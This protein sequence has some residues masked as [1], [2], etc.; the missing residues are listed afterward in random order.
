MRDAMAEREAAP[1]AAVSSPAADDPSATLLSRGFLVLLAIAAIVGVAV[2]LAAWCF[3][4]LIYQMQQE[5]YHH[6][7]SALGYSSGPPIWWSLPILAVAGVI[8]AL[9]IT[10]LP[11]GGGHIPAEGLKVGGAPTRP[12][13]LP[14]VILAGLASIGLGLVIGP[15]A[16]LIALGAGLAVA[17]VRLARRQAPSQ[18]LLVVGAAGSFAALS[19]VFSSPIIAAVILIEATGLGKSR[20]PIV[21]IPGLVG[22]GIGSLV[23]I[24]MG[25]FTGLSS[26][27]Y[28]LG[29][30]P[31]PGFHHP[32]AG[33]FA[34]T[35]ALALVVAVVAFLIRTGGLRTQRL[36]KPHPLLLLP[37][38]GLIV[39]GLAIAFS[40][41]SGK[42]INEALF[43]GQDALPGLI[44]S[45]GTWSLSALALLIGF[46]GLAYSIS[47][48]SFRG[49]PTFPAIFLGAAGG[50]MA[51][52][53]PGFPV[54]AAVAVGIGAG[55]V[56]ILRLPLSAVIIATLLTAK[57]GAGAEPLTIIGVV[58]SY[59]ATLRLAAIGATSEKAP[60]AAETAGAPA[61]APPAAPAAA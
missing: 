29:P 1:A 15:E 42:G 39:S 4:E 53:L 10:R 11:G 58:V 37:V 5:L 25:S 14:G 32:T 16:P 3:V 61:P 2:S 40:Q 19:F 8:T 13:D 17:I 7:P 45:A 47:L 38:C 30:L 22:A 12:I 18:V 48:G 41:S 20:L 44:S 26:S 21:L 24:G 56:A 46:K 60:A 51:S 34:W 50:I 49:G 59:L 43:S 54:T 23:S 9:A 33:N 52:H 55:T 28:A 57:S 35:I 6:L 36:V 31:L 27:A